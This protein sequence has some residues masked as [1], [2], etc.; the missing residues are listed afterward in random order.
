[1][2]NKN[3]NRID[4]LKKIVKDFSGKK[5]L[6]IGDLMVDEFIWGESSRLSPEAPVPVVL[7]KRE[8]KI[9]G[10]AFNVV[11]NLL[12]LNSKVFVVGKIGSDDLGS[13]IIDF[14]DKKGIDKSGIIISREMPT[15]IKTRIIAGHQQVVRLDRER[16]LEPNAEE[17]KRFIDY[18]TV[19]LPE[20]DGIIISDYAKGLINKQLLSKMIAAAGKSRVPV[21]VDPQVKNFM[22]YKNV[23]TLTP[24]HH[25]IGGVIGKVLDSEEFLIKTGKSLL[26]KLNAGSLLITRGKSGMT[27]FRPDGSFEHIPTVARK[28]F[29]VTGAGDTV[30]SVL[31]LAYISGAKLK[32]AAVLANI[33]AGYVVGEPGTATISRA[34]LLKNIKPEYLH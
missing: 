31:L 32:D 17:N 9:P 34:N 29:D 11:N 14:L 23:F 19:M 7:S 16:I 4:A 8:E 20:L 15:I 2:S 1:M 30:I 5:V 24:N 21:A 28:V 6:V 3:N 26:K 27:L 10:G 33:A 13:Y 22:S 12:D 25:E 18:I